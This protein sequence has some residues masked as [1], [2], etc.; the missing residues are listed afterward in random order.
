MERSTVVLIVTVVLLVVISGQIFNL[1][2]VVKAFCPLLAH[3]M[4]AATSLLTYLGS[5][6]LVKW[7][8]RYYGY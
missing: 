2:V 6:K 7:A 8:Y 5:N 3:A 4:V 1:F